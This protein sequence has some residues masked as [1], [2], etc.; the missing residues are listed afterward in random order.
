MFPWRSLWSTLGKA[1]RPERGLQLLRAHRLGA[2]GEVAETVPQVQPLEHLGEGG[3]GVGGHEQVRRDSVLLE[4][5]RERLAVGRSRIARAMAPDLD[6]LVRQ[7]RGDLAH[8]V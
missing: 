6:G 3:L 2:C 8:V 4:V 5:V 7:A 1:R